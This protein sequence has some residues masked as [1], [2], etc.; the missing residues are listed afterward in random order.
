MRRRKSRLP[1]KPILLIAVLIV[2]GMMIFNSGLLVDIGLLKGNIPDDIGIDPNDPRVIAKVDE[3]IDRNAVRDVVNKLVDLI[4]GRV[5]QG[6]VTVVAEDTSRDFKLAGFK[7]ELQD[8]ITKEVLETLVTGEDGTATSQLIDFKQAY[9]VVQIEASAPYVENNSEIII[10]MS[11]PIMELHYDQV[12]EPF[13]LNYSLNQEGIVKID[14]LKLDVPVLLQKPEL[15]NGCEITALTSLLNFAG[16]AIDK[17]TLSD[18]YLPMEPFYKKDN[19]LYGAD[20]NVAFSGDP[21]DPGGW[22]VYAAPT[23]KAGEDYIRSVAGNHEVLDLTGS[24][25][26]MIM[27]YVEQGKPIGI[28]ATRDLSLANFGYGWYLESTDTFFNAAT[29]LHCMVI[30]GYVGDKLYVMDPLEGSMIYDADTLFKSYE[31]L[32][33]RAMFVKELRNE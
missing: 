30:Y 8:A 7:F 26:E 28:W 24:T 32:G 16:Y 15:P 1:I 5:E 27:S 22:F 11:S 12:V 21:K 9:K 3:S 14:E 31:S 10:E 33:S 13:V 23:V 20:P 19:K 18:N 29:N 2:V 17:V 4:T 6:R 25:K